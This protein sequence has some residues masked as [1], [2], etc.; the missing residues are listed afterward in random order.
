MFSLFFYSARARERRKVKR[1]K[2]TIKV[3]M[4]PSDSLPIFSY[5]FINLPFLIG[6]FNT[7]PPSL[8]P[9]PLSLP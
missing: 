8:P 3:T 1:I 4:K 9:S 6:A 7:T 5:H 2:K